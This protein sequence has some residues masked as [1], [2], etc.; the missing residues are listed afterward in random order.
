MISEATLT[1]HED[2]A[3]SD[4]SSAKKAMEDHDAVTEDYMKRY[5]RLCVY[6]AILLRHVLFC[7]A[8]DSL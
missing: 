3:P 2:M 1:R 4:I 5:V 8:M 7:K 6:K